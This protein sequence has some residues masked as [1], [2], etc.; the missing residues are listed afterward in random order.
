MI[1]DMAG[2]ETAILV[3]GCAVLLTL[4]LC[5]AL[6]SAIGAARPATI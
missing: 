2:V 5:L 6:R 4:P 1:G 3:L